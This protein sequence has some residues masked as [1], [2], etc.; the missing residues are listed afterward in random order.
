MWDG[1]VEAEK[2]QYYNNLRYNQPIDR[3]IEIKEGLDALVQ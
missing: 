3:L 2:H 1:L